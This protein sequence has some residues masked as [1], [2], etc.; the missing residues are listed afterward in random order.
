M[1]TDM[2]T[3]WT[4]AA[5]L[6]TSFA[7]TVWVAS[8]LARNGHHF[9][10]DAFH[11]NELLAKAVNQLLVVGFYLINFGYVCLQVTANVPVTSAANA[12]EVFAQKLGWVLLVLGVMHF[13]NLYVINRYRK[14]S[15]LEN[16]PPPVRP[17]YQ[18]KTEGAADV[19]GAKR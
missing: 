1:E 14:R 3:F 17:D 8:V 15:A 16:A 7:V 4:Y 6:A 19:V 18:L 13:F 11:H 10:L 9:L 12:L 2:L 5:Y